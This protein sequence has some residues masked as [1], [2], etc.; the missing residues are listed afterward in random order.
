MRQQ[1]TPEGK[2]IFIYPGEQKKVLLKLAFNKA[3]QLHLLNAIP[4]PA[5]QTYGT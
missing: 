5:G 4:S 2:K 1:H 3:Q